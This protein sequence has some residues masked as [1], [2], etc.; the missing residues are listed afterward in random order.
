MGLDIGPDPKIFVAK[1]LTLIGAL[2]AQVM[3][4]RSNKCVHIP[5]KQEDD[6]IVSLP[7]MLPEEASV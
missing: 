6:G 4:D 5:P 7:Q 2:P 1:A 3:L